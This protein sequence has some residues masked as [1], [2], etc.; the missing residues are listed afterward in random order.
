MSHSVNSVTAPSRITLTRH[1]S[2]G[3]FSAAAQWVIPNS[4]G[5]SEKNLIDLEVKARDASKAADPLRPLR[6]LYLGRVDP[7]K[8]VD[9]LCAAFEKAVVIEPTLHLDVAGWGTMLETL[10]AQ[11]RHIPHLTFHGMV[12]GSYKDELLASSDAL[13]VP[14]V[15]EEVFGIVIIEAFAYGK[16]VI[17]TS[18]GAIP[19]LVT[20]GRTGYLVYPGD[21]NNLASLLVRLANAPWDLR[22][23]SLACLEAAKSYTL[24]SVTSAYLAAYDFGF[25]RQ[26]N[27][28]RR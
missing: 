14:S 11:Y 1:T 21:I 3:Y 24:E 18:I 19:E 23:M 12:E 15:W 28:R 20:P 22:E 13:I 10:R 2:L 17:A 25:F 6:F 7:P 4:H 26:K 8:G 16:P 27:I 9:V 5:Y